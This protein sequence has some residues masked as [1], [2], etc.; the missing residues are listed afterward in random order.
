MIKGLVFS[1][2]F[3][4]SFVLAQE[5]SNFI[6]EAAHEHGVAQLNIAQD[7]ETLFVEFISPSANL[8][9]FEYQPS[10]DEEKILVE[11]AITDLAAGLLL[12]SPS[13]AANCSLLSAEVESEIA[14]ESHS[15]EHSHEGHKNEE[16]NHHDHEHNDTH[17]EFHAT[18]EFNC[19]NVENLT[20]FD[21]SSLFRL[22]PDILDLDVQYALEN[23]QGAT[24]LNAMN[25]ELRF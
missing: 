22:Y 4:V 20:S 8:V 18:Y 7:A 15:E 10:S 1:L 11:A 25:T 16:E 5:T 13:E 19:S 24:E 21:L 2:C 9:G 3:L 14:E 23:S 12:F 17:S 6:E